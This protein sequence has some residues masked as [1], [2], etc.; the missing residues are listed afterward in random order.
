MEQSYLEENRKHA[1]NERQIK[2][3]NKILDMGVE[4]FK[5]GLNTKKYISLTKVSKATAARDITEL[6]GFGCISQIEGSAGRNIR[7]EIK[8]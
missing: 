7:Y 6:L 3:L 1:L 2:V 5:G 4:N 8:I